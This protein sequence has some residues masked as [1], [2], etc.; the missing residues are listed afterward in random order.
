[1]KPIGM[2]KNRVLIYE[3]DIVLFKGSEYTAYESGITWDFLLIPYIEGFEKTGVGTI[4]WVTTVPGAVEVVNVSDRTNYER[5]FADLC[6]EDSVWNYICRN[7]TCRDCIAKEAM[8]NA[9][10][11]LSVWLKEPAVKL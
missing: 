6:S 4:G 10:I 7:T 8:C 9:E 3:G 11:V 1:M 2:D 5:Y